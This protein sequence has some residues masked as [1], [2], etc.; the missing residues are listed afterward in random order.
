MQGWIKLHR[1]IRGHAFFKQKRKFSR[2]EAWVDMLLEANHCDKDWIAGNEI[3]TVQRGTFITSEL[4]LMDRWQWSKSKVRAFLKLL[5]DEQMIVKKTDNKKTGITI[6]NYELYQETE[7]AKEPEKDRK[8]TS[9]RPQKD[10]TKNVKNEKNEKNVK[11]VPLAEFVAMT[12]EEHQKLI[13]EH[14]ETVTAE[15][16]HILDN[17]KGST[18]KTYKDDYRAI[19]SWVVKRHEEDQAKGI[20][21]RG[22]KNEVPQAWDALREW[23]QDKEAQEREL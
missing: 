17:Y 6:V 1:Q 10:T 5:E 4:K 18:G 14:G 12:P 9:K 19:L 22:G 20:K 23:A 21:K 13:E 11:K 7:T 15:L 8:K 3:V 2:F 16:I